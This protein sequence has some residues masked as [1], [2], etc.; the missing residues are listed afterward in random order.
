MP[1]IVDH[2]LRRASIIDGFLR[3][4]ARDGIDGATTRSVSDELGVSTGSLWHYFPNFD[5]LITGAAA[6]VMEDTTRRISAASAGARGLARL[7]AI[8]GELLPLRRD[9]RDEAAIIV[10][11]WGRVSTRSV[12]AHAVGSDETWWLDVREAIGEAVADGELREDVSVEGLV[13]LLASVTYGQQVA[14]VADP[15]VAPEQHL[16]VVDAALSPWLH[17]H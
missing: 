1:K 3:V 8:M 13:H 15:T 14:Q 6:R 5:A 12:L 17:H 9:T 7:Y 4:V 10:N 2:D 11:F 16:A